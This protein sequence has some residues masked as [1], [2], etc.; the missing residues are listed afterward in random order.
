MY[1]GITSETVAV[2]SSGRNTFVIEGKAYFIYR[3]GILLGMT[4][5][6]PNSFTFVFVK[7]DLSRIFF[8]NLSQL[9]LLIIGNLDDLIII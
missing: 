7:N 8:V 3:V 2:S 4:K 1:S 5:S 9:D 6:P